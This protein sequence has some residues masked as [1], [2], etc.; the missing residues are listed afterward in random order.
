MSKRSLSAEQVLELLE[1]EEIPDTAEES[2]CSE[3][4]S[5]PDNQPGA[6]TMC[7]SLQDPQTTSAS[8][9]AQL[10][11]YYSSDDE[12]EEDSRDNTKGNIRTSRNGMYWSKNPPPQ[13]KTLISN[14]MKKQP[15]PAPGNYA[16][17]PK[18]AWDLFVTGD[19]LEEICMCSNLEGQ[20]TSAI[21]NKVFHDI[22]KKELLAFLGL[23]LLAGYEKNWDVPIRELFGDRLSNP[24]Y[25]A[26]MSIKRFEE[27]RRFLRFDD[28]RTRDLR[29]KTD[30]M[31]AFRY[32]WDLFLANCR[33]RF[34]PHECVTVDEQLVP[35][36][37]RCKFV[38]YMPSKPVKYGIKI[39]WCCDA[40]TSYA[41]DGVAYNG[42]QP[43]EEV[44]MNLASNI[45]KELCSPLRNT[46]RNITMDN[47]FTSV[48]LAEGLLEKGLTI[49]GTLL[50]NKPDVPTVMK[51]NKHRQLHSSE[52][53]FKG[54]I[55][56][57]SYVP[58]KN[59][60]V[61]F[62]STLHHEKSI[63]EGS[64]KNQPEIITYYNSTKGGVDVMDQMVHNYSCKRQTKRWPLVLWYNILDVASLNAYVLYTSQHPECNPGLMHKRRLFLKEL[65]LEL[66][67]PQMQSRLD[68]NPRLPR[69][70]I[71]SLEVFG[72]TQPSARS[73]GGHEQGPPKRRR[74]FYCSSSKDR[75]SNV[76][77]KKCEQHVCK[78][79][80]HVVC[81]KCLQ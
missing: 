15:G 47:S 6:D 48:P 13:R 41:L 38:Q 80:S 39:F 68:D 26:T 7:P 31:A 59:K 4:D 14:I 43:G 5:D 81:E 32:V 57:L 51:P 50:Q 58:K 61:L 17:S 23:S 76:M 46:G 28:K 60:A 66:V 78:E 70:I 16:M 20:R 12:T 25:R 56:M 19:I 34:V 36:R 67:T 27:I 63:M 11:E 62:L 69:N 75:K 29:L 35:F 22:S 18:D 37:G 10:P 64:I 44:Q 33:K 1:A 21:H 55:T 65:V 72:V 71:T 8:E 49:V 24:T 52:F 9:V 40:T 79:H 74:C 77:C 53:G 30:H 3:P 45:V 2:E 54:N 42:R 73:T